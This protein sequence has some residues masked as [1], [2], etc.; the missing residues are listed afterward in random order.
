MSVR[1]VEHTYISKCFALLVDTIIRK[2]TEIC[3][4]FG[5]ILGRLVRNY[6]KN[7]PRWRKV[8]EIRNFLKKPYRSYDFS[9][10]SQVILRKRNKVKI[11]LD[12]DTGLCYYSWAVKIQ[13]RGVEQSGS[14]SG[15]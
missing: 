15:S 2:T 11:V 14:S 8:R 7:V 13:Y 6:K 4:W 1:Y 12:N 9:V 3:K 10:N 5:R